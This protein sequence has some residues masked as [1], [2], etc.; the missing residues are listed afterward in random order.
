[1]HGIIQFHQ[2][3]YLSHLKLCI[4]RD[5]GFHHVDVH[6]PVS[7]I[8]KLSEVFKFNGL[9]MVEPDHDPVSSNKP[10]QV[11]DFNHGAINNLDDDNGNWVS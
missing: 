10:T 9:L 8:N 2:Q 5:G 4:Y 1:M 3:T 7:S 6:H 11:N